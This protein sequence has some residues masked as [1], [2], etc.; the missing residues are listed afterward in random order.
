MSDIDEKSWR[1]DKSLWDKKLTVEIPEAVL[2]PDWD[3]IEDKLA[4]LLLKHVISCSDGW[5]KNDEKGWGGHVTLHVNCN[6]VFAWGCADSEDIISSEI[7]ELYEMWKKDN[8]W[9]PAVW[10]IKKRK[11]M[12]QKPVEK[13]IREKG[14]WNLDEIKKGFKT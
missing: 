4:H 3:E 7:S 9:G 14:I 8:D 10:C 11:Q 6:D 13:Y 5:W 12:P 2:Q 1:K